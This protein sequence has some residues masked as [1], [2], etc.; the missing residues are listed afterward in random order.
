MILGAKQSV[1][2][3]YQCEPSEESSKYRS[4]DIFANP[5]FEEIILLRGFR[6]KPWQAFGNPNRPVSRRFTIGIGMVVSPF[7]PICYEDQFAPKLLICFSPCNIDFNQYNI[8]WNVN[9]PA[10]LF[11]VNLFVLLT[12]YCTAPTHLHPHI[13]NLPS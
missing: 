2:S 12:N 5:S 10:H 4:R 9:F 13:Y 7:P 3:R 8:V 11:V 1:I 6:L